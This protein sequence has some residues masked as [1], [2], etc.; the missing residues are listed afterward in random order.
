M[1]SSDF[2]QIGPIVELIVLTNP[3]SVLDVGCGFGKFGVLAR[4]YLELWDGRGRYGDRTRRIDAVE[5]FEPYITPLHRFIY[6]EIL[7]GDAGGIIPGIEHAYDLAL[8]IDVIEHQD[9]DAGHALILACLA[10][11]RNVLVATPK[12]P[13]EQGS[14]FGNPAETHRSSWQQADLQALPNCFIVPH[15]D[16]LICFAGKDAKRVWSA[17]LRARLTRDDGSVNSP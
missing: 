11:C 1:P 14:L 12:F 5:A 17:R 15:R 13:G 6:D 10:K 9:R 2:N 16:S 7:I 4:E 8:L 3:Q